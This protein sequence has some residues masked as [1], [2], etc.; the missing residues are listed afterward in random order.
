MATIASNHTGSTAAG[1]PAPLAFAPLASTLL[2]AVTGGLMATRL[3][4]EDVVDTIGFT[5]FPLVGG[6]LLLRGVAP[7]VGWLFGVLGLFVGLGL[8][9]GGY[10]DQGLPGGATAEVLS[11]S[12]FVALITVALVFVPLNLPDGQLPSPRWR[13]VA[14]AGALVLASSLTALVLMPGPVDEDRP[15]GPVNP[16][17]IDAA[18]GVLEIVELVSL[19]GFAVLALTSLTSLALRLRGATERVRRQVRILAAGVGVLVGLFLLDS[20]LQGIFGDV[21]GVLAAIVATSAV[22]IATALALLADRRE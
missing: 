16:L 8:F 15:D 21:Y 17:G 5:A 14:G 9:L 7:R 4:V 18:E 1:T 10:A 3:E 2:L 20:T 13:P 19:I 11:G 6:L 12:L 22:P